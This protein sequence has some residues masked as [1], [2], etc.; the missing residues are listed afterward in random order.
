MYT[1]NSFGMCCS[2]CTTV[3]TLPVPALLVSRTVT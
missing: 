3:Q 1:V 2:M